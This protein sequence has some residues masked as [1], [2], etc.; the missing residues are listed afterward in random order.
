MVLRH[1]L[2]RNFEG[3]LTP[4]G[5]LLLLVAADLHR[6]DDSLLDPVTVFLVHLRPGAPGV[7]GSDGDGDAAHARCD[8]LVVG[9]VSASGLWGE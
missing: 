3:N 7:D 2:R 1:T 9:D 5:V 4:E 6:R 8:E